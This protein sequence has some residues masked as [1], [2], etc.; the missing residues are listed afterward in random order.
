MDA[1]PEGATTLLNGRTNVE[2]KSGRELVVTR[3]FDAPARIVF[4]AWKKP[5]LFMRWWAPK[6]MGMVLLSCEMDVRAGGSYRRAFGHDASKPGAFFGRYIEVTPYSRLVW[7]NDEGGDGG[8]VTTVTFEEKGGK[9]LLTVS[10]L[11]PSKDALDAGAGAADAMPEQFEQLDAL[12]VTM[13]ESAE[14]V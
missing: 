11:Y 14:R 13:G 10:E 4:E 1:R 12:L 9:T 5:E 8:S 3:T 7:T 6:S 2:R